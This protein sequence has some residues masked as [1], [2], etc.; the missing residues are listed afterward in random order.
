MS[1][2][3]ASAL[4][5]KYQVCTPRILN[6]KGIRE[7]ILEILLNLKQIILKSSTET[8]TWLC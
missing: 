7:D 8:L 6:L 2:L 1:N 3:K 4:T 5:L